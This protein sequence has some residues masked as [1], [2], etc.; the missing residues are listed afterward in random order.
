MIVAIESTSRSAIRS[1]ITASSTVTPR[2]LQ[3]VE[4]PGIDG[5]HVA[6][7]RQ[8][9]AQ[10]FDDVGAS[11]CVSTTSITAS[12]SL[13]DPADLIGRRRVV[14][15]H[16]DRPGGKDGVVEDHPFEPGVR[17]E[18]DPI[19]RRNSGRDE[20]PGDASDHLDDVLHRHVGEVVTFAS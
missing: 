7:H 13:D 14:D 16:R 8:V 4:R 12:L 11:R 19:T 6:A 3:L 17:H 5:Q 1:S 20:A 9:G 18:R 10:R 2:V 15:R